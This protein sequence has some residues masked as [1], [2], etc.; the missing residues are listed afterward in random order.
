MNNNTQFCTTKMFWLNLQAASLKP[1][2]KLKR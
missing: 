2:D 1:E